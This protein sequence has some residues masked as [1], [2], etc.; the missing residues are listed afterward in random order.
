MTAIL[1]SA[2]RPCHR[3]GTTNDETAV[4]TGET[5]ADATVIE[6]KNLREIGSLLLATTDVVQDHAAPGETTDEE[7]SSVISLLQIANISLDR[8]DRDRDYDRRKDDRRDDYRRGDPPRR[9]EPRRGDDHRDEPRRADDHR[10]PREGEKYREERAPSGS[11][12]GADSRRDVPKPRVEVVAGVSPVRP[13]FKIDQGLDSTAPLRGSL[14]PEAP[15]N[16]QEEG[17]AMDEDGGDEEAAMMAAMGLAGFG[18]TKACIRLRTCL[19]FDLFT[20][21]A[22]PR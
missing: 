8:R 1:A 9:D 10:R 6:E 22:C 19:Y 15:T 4:G 17:E 2:H 13:A 5:E 18:T 14:D 16:G 7:V 20:G 21:K 11:A 12:G 3:A